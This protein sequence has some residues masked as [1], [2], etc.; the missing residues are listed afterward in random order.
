MMST[1]CSGGVD[2]FSPQELQARVFVERSQNEKLHTEP[3]S[4]G[5]QAAISISM[6]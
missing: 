6:P 2:I 3:K 1:F 4:T 5:F